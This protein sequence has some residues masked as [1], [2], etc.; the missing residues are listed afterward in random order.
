MSY[1]AVRPDRR[2]WRNGLWWCVAV[3]A[4]LLSSAGAAHTIRF[5]PEKDY[6]PFVSA[7]PAGHV[8]GLSVDVLEILRPRL[9]GELQMLPP[10][11]LA[12]ILDAARRGEVDLISSLRPTPERAEFLAFT[13]PYVKVPAVLVVKQ[14]PAA[15]VLADL[16]GR[17]VAVGK[18]YAVETFVR[19]HY[20]QIR[21][22]AVSDDMSG[23]QLLMRGEVDGVVADVASISDAKRH[24]GVRG[25]QVGE[26]LP[27]EYAL[28]FAYRKELTALGSALNTALQDISPATR[29][30]L[31]RRWID[32]DT[33]TYEDPLHLW[34]RRAALGLT[35][36]GVLLMLVWR[37]RKPLLKD[38]HPR[39]D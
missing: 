4:G 23:F 9:G 19:T 2:H 16:A 1:Q 33:L 30:A 22:V 12:N 24:S 25:V 5:A 11:N 13:E 17:S 29:Q 6:P 32:V 18:G 20:P 26:T 36:L 3:C 31:L 35:F 28:S 21:W 27:F 34:L 15:P 8:Q 37:A 38:R 14:G 39:A 7:G 10:D